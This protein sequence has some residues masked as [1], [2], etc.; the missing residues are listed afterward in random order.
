MSTLAAL[1]L[2]LGLAAPLWGQAPDLPTEAESAF[3]SGDLNR[4][5]SLAGRILAREPGSSPA[6]MILGLVAAQRSQWL[7]A[8]KSF[9]AVIRIEPS[10]PF[11]YFYLGQVSLN[12]Q[13]WPKAVQYFSKA[14]EH[15]YPDRGRLMVELALAENEAGQPQQALESLNNVQAPENGSF[16]AQYH[17]V[18]AFALEK[19]NQPGPALDDMRQARDIDDSNPQYWEFLI[20]TLIATDQ[21]NLALMEAIRAQR[22]FP[23][24]ADVQVLLGLAGYYNTQLPMTKLALR[25]LQEAQPDSAWVPLLKGLEDRLEGRAPDALRAFAEAAKRGVPDA[26]LLL[27]IVFRESGDYAA[28]EREYREAERLN[29]RNGQAPLEFG[30]LLLARGDL[31]GAL[32]RLERAV[33]YMPGAPAAHY[34]L[35]ILY[36]RLGQKEKG[37]EQMRLWRQLT[38]EQAEAAR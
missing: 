16:S 4:A 7:A 11:G 8:E 19:L 5:A 21:T 24:S 36:G 18:K 29:P 12:Q 37:E 27:G 10:N 35:G 1:L 3:R 20:S 30:K 33:Q 26:H 14:L 31:K 25:N 22:R 15:Q 28:A 38:K 17:A 2:S 6:H 32:T 23:D 13:K 34:Q 9:G